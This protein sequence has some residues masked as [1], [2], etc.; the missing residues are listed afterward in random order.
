MK[1]ANKYVQFEVDSRLMPFS[2]FGGSP[3]A[4]SEQSGNDDEEYQE[5]TE[6]DLDALAR[7]LGG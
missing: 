3:N 7:A 6:Q 5:V 2:I 4:G 1:Q